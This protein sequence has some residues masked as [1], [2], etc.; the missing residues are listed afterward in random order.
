MPVATSSHVA[1]I[2]RVREADAEARAAQTRVF[3]LAAEWADA[4]LDPDA[5]TT[6]GECLYGCRAADRHDVEVGD[7]AGG[8][9]EGC[10]GD[11]DGFHDPFIPVVRW[12]AAAPFGAAIGRTS[13]A[14]SLMMRDA[15]LTRHR[16]PRVWRRMESGEVEPHKARMLAQSVI[17]RPR[18]VSDH[19]DRHLAPVAHKIGRVALERAIDEAMLRLYPEQREAE[20][21]EALDRRFAMLHVDS[22]N[23]VGI[24]D[25]SV[26]GDWKDLHDFDRTLSRVA[27]ALAA[28]D[29]ASGLV[30][31]SLDVR[32][33]R[34]V[35]VLA[36][37]AAALALLSGEHAPAPSKRAQLVLTITSD[38]LTGDPVAHN[39]TTGRAV[40]EQAVREW[41]GRTDTHLQVL[42]VLDLA[43]HDTT[44]AYRPKEATVAAPSSWPRGACSRTAP[45]RRLPATTTTSSPT[46]TTTRIAAVPRAT[47]T[48][49]PC[50]D[51]ITSS[52]P[53]PD[54]ATRSSTPASGSGP[55]RTA[56]SSSA[57]ASAR[58]T[59]PRAGAVDGRSDASTRPPDGCRT[60]RR[61]LA[62]WCPRRGVV[63]VTRLPPRRGGT[64]THRRRE[65]PGVPP[66]QSARVNETFGTQCRGLPL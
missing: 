29:E 23:H 64:S 14:G 34:A 31:D 24:A 19:L 65:S 26:R 43:G 47:A 15:L 60:A 13:Q 2:G 25:M 40:L 32:R 62:R 3:L 58:P 55:T 33:S 50:A 46:T 7:F 28:Q 37:P 35:G 66:G 54:G 21:L 5:P 42:P 63:P 18:D 20:Q 38:G 12:D 52:R 17:G 49:R 10:V 16:L 36:D 11:P 44:D 51:I 8:C 45:V 30:P 48:S 6:S 27:I 9:A 22:I 56:S 4:H 41:C 57:T 61:P 1:L 39:T 59:S 53:T